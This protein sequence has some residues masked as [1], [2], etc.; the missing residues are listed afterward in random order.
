MPPSPATTPVARSANL[1]LEVVVR[2]Q[3]AA[4]GVREIHDTRLCT[5]CADPALLFSHRRDAGRTG[6][7]A[8]V[9]WRT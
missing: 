8:G 3:L 1:A 6:R 5:M 9:A 2:D 7:Q 4:L